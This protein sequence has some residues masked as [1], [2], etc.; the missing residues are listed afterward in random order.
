MKD[1]AYKAMNLAHELHKSQLRK[2]TGTP[3]TDHLAEVAAIC[4]S[5]GPAAFS[6]DLQIVVATCWLH[7]AIEDQGA[8]AASLEKV[9]GHE[10]AQGVLWL[11]DIEQGNR[12]ERK[13]AARVRLARAPD[14]VQTIKCADLISNTSSIRQRDPNFAVVYLAEAR[15]LLAALGAADPR[16]KARALAAVN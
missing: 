10:V 4:A 12:S 14:W 16:L 6:V 5:C 3:Y 2:Y 8:T 11:S 1:V 13:A 7:D 9:V 15:L